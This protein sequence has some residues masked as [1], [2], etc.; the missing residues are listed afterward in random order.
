MRDCWMNFSQAG[1]VFIFFEKN[2]AALKDYE[3][4]VGHGF[5]HKRLAAIKTIGSWRWKHP[6]INKTMSCAAL[7]SGHR[8]AESKGTLHCGESVSR[9]SSPF[10]D[11]SRWLIAFNCVGRV[12]H[13]QRCCS[14]GRPLF[15]RPRLPITP[16]P[17]THTQPLKSSNWM[18]LCRHID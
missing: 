14:A 11:H 5:S 4:A 9:N 2:S 16:P 6:G 13:T 1:S 7:T 3:K 12:A 18:S 10:V 8:S 15:H 17:H